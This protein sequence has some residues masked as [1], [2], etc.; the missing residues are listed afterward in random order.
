MECAKS[1]KSEAECIQGMTIVT[2]FVGR[3]QSERTSPG[4]EQELLRAIPGGTALCNEHMG[5]Q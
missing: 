3:W 1:R 2:A 4:G 5:K